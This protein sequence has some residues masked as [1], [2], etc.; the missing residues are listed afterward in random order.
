M[1][2]AR[3]FGSRLAWENRDQRGLALAEPVE[4]GDYV[5]E[6]FKAIHA[7]STA[8]E[9]SG[10]LWSAEEKHAEDGD[11]A[12]VEIE[13]FLQPVLVFGHAAIGAPGGAS[14]TFFLQRRERLADRLFIQSHHRVTIVFLIAGV[15]QTHSATADSNPEW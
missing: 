5:V 15:D 2:V 10:S 14:E 7:F 11:F 6:S 8:A 1:H 12:A 9:F 3:F 13:N 4:R